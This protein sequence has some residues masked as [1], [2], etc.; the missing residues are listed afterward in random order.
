ML[1]SREKSKLFFGEALAAG[2]PTVDELLARPEC[3]WITRALEK[4]VMDYAITTVVPDHLNG[5][6]T[7][8]LTLIHKPRP[9]LRNG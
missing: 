2:E 6:R 9:P 8:K 5:V 3:G 4:Q 7:H 1:Q